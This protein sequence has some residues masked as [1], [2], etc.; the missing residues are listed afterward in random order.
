MTG[1][2][3]RQ[4]LALV[5]RVLAERRQMAIT[6]AGISPPP[7]ITK[8][9][10]E[11]PRDPAKARAW[12]RGVSQIEGYRQSHGVTDQDSALGT[13]RSAELERGAALRRLAEVQRALGLGQHA[14]RVHQLGRGL[15]IGR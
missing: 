11:R 8:E 15:G 7:Y 10:G 4:E 12:D 6:A 2:A 5:D 14:S 9:L 1:N 13:R 3:A